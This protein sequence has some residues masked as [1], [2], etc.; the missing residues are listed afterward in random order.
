MIGSSAPMCDKAGLPLSADYWGQS[1]APLFNQIK[2]ISREYLSRN[3]DN[4]VI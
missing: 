4:G 3:F 2:K 1:N